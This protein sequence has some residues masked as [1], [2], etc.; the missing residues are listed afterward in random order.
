MKGSSKCS[1]PAEHEESAVAWVERSRPCNSQL[2]PQRHAGEIRVWFMLLAWIFLGCFSLRQ[3][4]Q[5][6]PV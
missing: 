3:D 1:C 6:S 4:R 5:E 2:S